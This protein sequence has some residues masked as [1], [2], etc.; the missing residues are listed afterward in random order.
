[1]TYDFIEHDPTGGRTHDSAAA[2]HL[3]CPECGWDHVHPEVEYNRPD[4]SK[5]ENAAFGYSEQDDFIVIKLSC[6][7]GHVSRLILGNHKG[8]GSA[9]TVLFDEDGKRKRI[10]TKKRT[11]TRKKY[12]VLD[13]IT[14]DF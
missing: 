2:Y 7:D 12:L 4:R 3:R 11:G 6:E 5:Y 8:E 13:E 14:S 1:M 10:Q 9:S